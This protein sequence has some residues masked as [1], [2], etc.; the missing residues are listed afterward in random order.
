MM[1]T[2]FCASS[3]TSLVVFCLVSCLGHRVLAETSQTRLGAGLCPDPSATVLQAS[4]EAELRATVN[5]AEAN[6]G[7]RYCIKMVDDIDLTF[8]GDDTWGQGAAIEIKGAQIDLVGAKSGSAQPPE[9]RRTTRNMKHFLIVSG[10]QVNMGNIVVSGGIS[11]N[12]GGAIENGAFL[13]MVRC[14]LRNNQA[15]YAGA[16]SNTGV[17]AN[18]TVQ[19]AKPPNT[20]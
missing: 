2:C 5:T 1:A 15:S 13:N 14:T 3:V 9:L 17:S 10:A 11:P 8:L 7:T 12:A 6:T 4:T 19:T 18:Y 20:H 16:I